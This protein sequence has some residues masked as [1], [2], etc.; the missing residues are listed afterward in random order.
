MK[1]KAL[2]YINT[3]IHL[4]GT[5]MAQIDINVESWNNRRALVPDAHELLWII[6]MGESHSLNFTCILEL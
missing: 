4:L 3:H 2:P 5:N 1:L 6:I